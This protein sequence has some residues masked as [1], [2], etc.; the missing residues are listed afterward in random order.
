MIINHDSRYIIRNFLGKYPTMFYATYGLKPLNRRLSV[1]RDTEFVIEGYPRSAN[2]FAVV[3][4]EY[5]NPRIKLAH[6]LHVPA[7][8]IRAAQW[9]IPI[10]VLIREPKE[11]VASSIVRNPE[12]SIERALNS[13]V[14]FY[15]NIQSYSYSYIVGNFEDIVQD[16]SKVIHQVN[17]KFGTKFVAMT[18][19]GVD[20]DLIFSKIHNYDRN[21]LR[22]GIPSQKKE[23]SKKNIIQDMEKHNKELLERAIMIYHQFLDLT[24]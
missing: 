2:T 23:N 12:Q 8:I 16:Y 14:S 6:H 3:A 7:Q 4:F 1:D 24:K 15:K 5:S 9:K 11:A 21:V 20:K 13:Y 17:H 22:L 19:T 18:P 10:L